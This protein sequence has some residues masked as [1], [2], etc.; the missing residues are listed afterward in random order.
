MQIVEEWQDPHEMVDMVVDT[1]ESPPPE[2]GN[3][4]IGGTREA[5]ATEDTAAESFVEGDRARIALEENA[6]DATSEGQAARDAEARVSSVLEITGGTV[7]GTLGHGS[8]MSATLGGAMDGAE[9]SAVDAGSACSA[10]VPAHASDSTEPVVSPS[11]S[12]EG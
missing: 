4:P 5:A 8:A 1:A 9:D 11:S 2:E 3:Y 10:D 12:S 7:E 6:V